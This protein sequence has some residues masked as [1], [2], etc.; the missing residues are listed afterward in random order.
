MTVWFIEWHDCLSMTLNKFETFAI[1][2]AQEIS[3]F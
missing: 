3:E 2:T 1:S